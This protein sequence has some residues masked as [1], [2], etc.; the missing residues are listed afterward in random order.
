LNINNTTSKLN[1]SVSLLSSESSLSL[2]LDK[3]AS[4]AEVAV[5]E[6]INNLKKELEAMILVCGKLSRFL[7]ANSITP[8]N[9][10]TAKYIEHFILEEQTKQK[11]GAKNDEV[12]R[13]LQA[14]LKAY[15][16]DMALFSMVEEFD[17][18][19]VMLMPDDDSTTATVDNSNEVPKTEE[20][21][22]LVESL[23]ALPINGD[24]IRLQVE[25]L[26]KNQTKN[27]Q[28]REQAIQLPSSA[29]SPMIR[30]RLKQTL[31]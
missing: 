1:R 4:S 23:Y 3:H 6:L 11:A 9:D 2:S 12:I 19:L 27:I 5:N 7:R 15:E 21:F 29:T 17:D 10:D 14:T 31:K 13:G 30:D 20:I 28:H 8:Y 26:K 24:K 18:D 16:E 22:P 25:G